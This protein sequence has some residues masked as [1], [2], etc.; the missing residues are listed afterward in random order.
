MEVYLNKDYPP[1]MILYKLIFGFAFPGRLLVPVGPDDQH[2]ITASVITHCLYS[3]FEMRN[4]GYATASEV[5]IAMLVILLGANV[6]GPAAV[7]AGTWH[8]R[9][10]V[11]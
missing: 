9:E 4:L 5:T 2:S 10:N 7:Y 3:S 6:V 1:L 8:W 11:I